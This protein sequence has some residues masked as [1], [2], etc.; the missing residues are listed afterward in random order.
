[1]KLPAVLH[2]LQSK[3]RDQPPSQPRCKRCSLSTISDGS[4]ADISQP[5]PEESIGMRTISRS[6]VSTIKEEI[7]SIISSMH[8]TENSFYDPSQKYDYRVRDPPSLKDSTHEVIGQISGCNTECYGCNL[9]TDGKCREKMLDWAFEMVDYFNLDRSIVSVSTNYQDR[10]LTTPLGES[11]RYSREEF[12]IASVTCLYIAIKLHVPQT[13]N[14]TANAFAH[15]CHGMISGENIDK[16]EI[17]ILFAL[18]WK[19]NPPI[20]LAYTELYLDLLFHT[21]ENPVNDCGVTGNFIQL[22]LNDH[23]FSRKESNEET[24]ELIQENILQLTRYQL[25][26]AAHNLM[27]LSTNSS[28]IATAAILNSVEGLM[29]LY[30]G[31]SSFLHQCKDLIHETASTCHLECADELEHVSL[32]LL[33]CIIYTEGSNLKEGI[34]S[35][36]GSLQKDTITQSSS[37]DSQPISPR[38]VTTKKFLCL[39]R[40]SPRSVLSRVSAMHSQSVNFVQ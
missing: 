31:C 14:I 24:F 10:F 35:E 39:E 37:S 19:V 23:Y 9:A 6:N 30:S 34:H 13:W 25:E 2:R 33:S 26:N 8:E 15:L 3:L 20:P 4:P 11:A 27:F 5:R 29:K 18:G 32:K 21:I 40:E 7:I 1:M 12:R 16:M 22:S 17:R 28:T 36:A 38:S